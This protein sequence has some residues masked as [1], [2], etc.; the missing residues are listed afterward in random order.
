MKN[1]YLLLCLLCLLTCCKPKK[2]LSW[3]VIGDSITYLDAHP[4]EA[5]NRITAGYMKRV[6]KKLPYIHYIN[7]GYNGWASTQIAHAINKLKLEKADIYSVFL[8]TNDWW[9]GKPIGR[10]SDYKNNTGDST[11]FGA[12]RVIINKLHDLN[13]NAHI[14]LITPMQRGDFVYI[15]NFKNNA[16]GSYKLKNGQS[17]A[18]IADA[19]NTIAQLEKLDMVDLYYKSG[20]TPQNAVKYKRLKDTIPGRY[21]PYTYPAYTT[22]AFN[23]NTDNYPYPTDAIDMTYDGLHPSD[24][25]FNIIAGMLV[26][27]MKKY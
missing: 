2:D 9:Q 20:I 5:G 10:L 17:L 4:D 23:P 18:N 22:I 27:V 26:K 21:K 13:G 15:K 12:Y 11:I 19:I 1:K 14:I 25:G 3:T 24:K 16:Y 7:Q 8:G 6:T